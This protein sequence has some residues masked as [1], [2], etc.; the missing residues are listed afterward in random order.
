MIGDSG[1]TKRRLRSL[2]P[3]GWLSRSLRPISDTVFGGLADSLSW[4]YSLIAAAKNLT[5]LATTAGWVLDLAAW[6]FF[7]ARFLRHKNELDDLWRQRI[8]AEIFRERVTRK[9]I[10]EALVNL[11][12]RAPIIFEPWNPDDC[13][14]GYGAA[15]IRCPGGRIA[16]GGKRSSAATGAYGRWGGYS[17]GLMAYSYSSPGSPVTFTGS[18]SYG[19]YAYPYQV[20][21]TAFRPLSPG[22]PFINGYNGYNGGYGRGIIAYANL[23]QLQSTLPDAEIYA[24]VAQIKAAGITAWVR[25]KS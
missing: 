24:A 8:V 13:G 21:I 14:A 2:I 16:Y 25:I 18:G 10:T 22:I 15:G 9:G 6:D 23:R 17:H 3:G 11:T 7:G 19:S 5:R 20:F 12:G 1:D 4:A